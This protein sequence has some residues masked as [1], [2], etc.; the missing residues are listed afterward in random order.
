MN[1]LPND[2]MPNRMIA[3]VHYYTPWNFCGMSSDASWGKMFYFWGNNY[4]STTNPSRNATWGEESTVESYFQ[5]MKTK[6]FDKGIPIILG[7]YGAIKRTSLT[8][9]DLALHIASREYW[10]QYITN[11][12]LRYGMIPF[13]WDNGIFD[14]NNGAVLDQS[15]LDAIMR[16]TTIATSVQTSEKS[17]LNATAE[18]VTA[19]P[20]PV[21]ASTLGRAIFRM[22]SGPRMFVIALPAIRGLR[23]PT[24]IRTIPVAQL[25][26]PVMT[27]STGVPASRPSPAYRTIQEDRRLMIRPVSSVISRTAVK[28][29]TLPS[30]A[31]TRFPLTQDN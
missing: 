12:A 6:F 9:D 15:T 31:L 8:G 10:F 26:G 25:A 11:A 29:S 20:N 2:K 22:L 14:R 13:C 24:I 5:L 19:M 21:R 3:E 7:E 4:H 30:L 1:Q 17:E 18:Y 23:T 28:S 27:R 16:G